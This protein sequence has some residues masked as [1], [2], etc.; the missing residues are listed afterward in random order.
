MLACKRSANAALHGSTSILLAGIAP[1]RLSICIRR[2][3]RLL[4]RRRPQQLQQEHR[5]Q[6]VP[7]QPH[8]IQEICVAAATLQPQL[9]TRGQGGGSWSACTQGA[10]RGTQQLLCSPIVPTPCN[11]PVSS[12]LPAAPQ[13][14][15]PG[16]ATA[17]LRSALAAGC[18]PAAVGPA[19]E[20]WTMVGQ[21]CCWKGQSQPLTLVQTCKQAAP[22]TTQSAAMTGAGRGCSRHRSSA[23]ATSSSSGRR[24]KRRARGS[25]VA[26]GSA[27]ST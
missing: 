18:P 26:A 14:P 8:P 10:S 3:C 12:L 21:T 19:A 15:G 2:R 9:Q 24:G 25:M 6:A 22:L 4:P 17:G 27:R 11:T 7:E 20:Q 16:P 5:V 23:P 13:P 1:P